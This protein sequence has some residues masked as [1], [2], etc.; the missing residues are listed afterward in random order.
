MNELKT[1]KLTFDAESASGLTDL[2][3]SVLQALVMRVG[4]SF[5]TIQS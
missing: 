3:Y 2:L 4:T 5:V 1:D